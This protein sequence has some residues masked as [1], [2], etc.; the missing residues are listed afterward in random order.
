MLFIHLRLKINK[1]WTKKL[2]T[3]LPRMGGKIFHNEKFFIRLIEVTFC[4]VFMTIRDYY[5]L[6]WERRDLNPHAYH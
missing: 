2:K 1:S 6:S 3:K 4:T 5:I